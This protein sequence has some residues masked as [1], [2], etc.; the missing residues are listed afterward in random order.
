MGFK[1]HLV[2]LAFFY[3]WLYSYWVPGPTCSGCSPPILQVRKQAQKRQ[4]ACPRAHGASQALKPGSAAVRGLSW[5]RL[6]IQTS[7]CAL[8]SSGQLRMAG[9]TP[10]QMPMTLEPASSGGRLREVTGLACGQGT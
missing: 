3:H 1:A 9:A 5:L 8:I 4:V 7:A 10:P 6:G 2:C